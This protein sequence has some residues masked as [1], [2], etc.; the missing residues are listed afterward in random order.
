ME[1][2]EEASSEGSHFKRRHLGKCKEDEGHKQIPSREDALEER[3]KHFRVL[4]ESYYLSRK[5]YW[6]DESF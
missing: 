2:L 6:M 5:P 1:M 3:R 4:G